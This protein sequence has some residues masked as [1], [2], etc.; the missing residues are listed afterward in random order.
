MKKMIF[1]MTIAA[2]LLATNFANAQNIE[3]TAKVHK[4]APAK[5]GEATKKAPEKIQK[6]A[7]AT[8]AAPV[9]TKNEAKTMP[10][11]KTKATKSP[12]K[13]VKAK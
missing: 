9:I 11:V 2:G 10:P 5:T 6:T 4:A 12:A 1:A 8:N 3:K 13:E 7:P